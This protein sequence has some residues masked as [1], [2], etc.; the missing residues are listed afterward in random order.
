MRTVGGLLPEDM[1]LRVARDRG[2]PGTAPGDYGMVGVSSVSDEA[3]RLWPHL[4]AVWRELRRA[5]PR[6]AADAPPPAD[7]ANAA[8]TRWVGPLLEALGFGRLAGLRSPGVTADDDPERTLAVSHRYAQALVHI[9]PWSQELDRREHSGPPPQSLV[10]EALNRASAHLWG[11]VT[12]G[13]RLRL[14]RDSNSL[15]GSTYVEIDLAAVFDGELFNEFVLI[16]QLL[17]ASRF[18][19]R[20]D[21]P[22]STC[23]LEEWREEAMRS[24]VRA[25]D[26]LRDNVEQAVTA[27]GT[28][29]LCHPAN[30]A[31]RASPDAGRLHGALLRLVFRI[32]FLMVV[33]D[34]DLLHPPGAEARERQRYAAYF[35][36][37][38]LRRTA[39]RR[40]GTAHSDLYEALRLVLD[41]L[42]DEE[43]R[44]EI[45]LVGLGGLFSPTEDDAPLRGMRLSNEALLRATRSLS[46]VRD[47][48]SRRWRRVSFRTLSSRELGAVY[49]SLLETVPEYG[50]DGRSFR[51]VHRAGNTRKT[52]GAYYT[53]ASLI[54]R[55][56]DSA[57]EPVLDDAVKRGEQLA[58]EHAELDP[59]DTIAEML[60]SVTVC[61]PAC[62]SGH[63][64][65]AAGHRI[66]KRVAAYREGTLEP[67]EEAYRHALHDVVARC[68]YGVDLNPM[69]VAI[70]R[71]SLWLEGMAAGRPLDLL[72]PHLKHGNA[73]VGATPRQ[74]DGGIP[75]AAFTAVEGDD[76][77][78]A[79][80]FQRANQLERQGQDSLFDPEEE[81]RL[82]NTDFSYELNCLYAIRVG[83]LRDVRRQEKVYRD[84]RESEAYR[85]QLYIADTWCA[86]FFWE[87]RAGAARPVTHEAFETLKAFEESATPARTHAEIRRLGES[88]RFFHWHLEFPDIFPVGSDDAPRGEAG[89]GWSGG[90]DCV[91]A[92]P[93]WDKLDFEDKK[94]FSVV[95]PSIARIAG[96]ARRRRIAEWAQE[97]PEAGEEYR[98]AR[99]AVKSTFHFAARSGSYEK[100][101]EGLK[102]KGVNSLQA[103]QLFVERF[104]A[105]AHPEGRIGAIAPTALATGAGAQKLF[106]AFTRRRRVRSFYDFENLQKIFSA[107]D[108]RQRFCLLTL[109][110]GD[111]PAPA[112]KYA[113]FVH[114]PVQLDDQRKV[115]ELNPD[116]IEL[117]SP[118]TGS[119]PAFRSRRDA[120]LTTSVYH[121]IPV[122]QK[123]GKGRGNPW[124]IRF[125]NLFNMTDDSDLFRTRVDLEG[126]GWVLQGNVF[127]RDRQRMLPLYEAKM[128]HHFDHRWNIFSGAKG[129]DVRQL[130]PAE[131]HDPAKAALPRYW[132]PEGDG[133]A[134]EHD[135]RGRPVHQEGVSTRL[136]A[137]GWDRHWL[138]GW[139]D[140]TNATNE[141]TAIPAF[142][143]RAAVGH[144]FPLMFSDLPGSFMAGLCAVQSS[145][146]FDYIS[147]QKISGSSMGLFVWKQLPVPRPD[148]LEPHLDFFVPRV[149]ELVYTA[150]DMEPLARDLGHDGPPF[151]WD[152]ERRAAIRAEL[153][154]YMFH[155]YGLGREDTEYVLES[156]QT[157]SGGLKNNEIARYG[158]YRTKD[159]VLEV[160]DRMASTGVSIKSPL[161]DNSGFCSVL[162]P[163]PGQWRS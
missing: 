76:A 85:R 131:K 141:R 1:L 160:F 58:T 13:R 55:L 93:P 62:G 117:L 132:V 161:G 45:A 25:L 122:L 151:A 52:T 162:E 23:R 20:G 11:I 94:Y 90:F 96:V 56:L 31:L 80:A 83:S 136:A 112:A 120:D 29:F 72:D 79:A 148:Q 2:L 9:V 97:D 47:A 144:K 86:A 139:R 3:E 14:L 78:V 140:V 67:P 95:E 73:L 105:L 104:T 146:V 21:G 126:E 114:D 18:E 41:A 17:H 89:A 37:A 64:L 82:S 128:A 98:R 19:A 27:L 91:L 106:D 70:A 147:R 108:A 42:G 129:D 7:P 68:L 135:Y 118:N 156:F 71:M 157:S 143:P 145:L 22:P 28:G 87:K 77:K 125:R 15:A 51:L 35:S 34:R 84:W 92:N 39:D 57:L 60:L 116:E 30:T 12:N 103:D 115:F 153:D 121:S 138:Y 66:A 61:D 123:E 119:L 127:H 101:A 36:T 134:G 5:L 44:P 159:M 150:H 154:A 99:R 81:F 38:R 124:G 65:V 24:G 63:F 107:V 102:V 10:Q 46:R 130:G 155:L 149:L 111:R 8:L 137:S 48:G 110:S 59:A 142:V 33:E 88:H 26:A 54:S 50:A 109:D 32:V 43:G 158:T 100:C 113:F 4:L 74:I 69:A 152:E 6:E 40:G 49:E 133:P 53:P 163:P 75:D 16:L